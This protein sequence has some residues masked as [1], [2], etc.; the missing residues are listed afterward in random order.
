VIVRA[1]TLSLELATA[2][3]SGFVGLVFMASR[4]IEDIYK[5]TCIRKDGSRFP[6]VGHGGGDCRKTAEWKQSN[7]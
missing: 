5:L 4:G 1:K 2:M 3:A 6:A 7:D